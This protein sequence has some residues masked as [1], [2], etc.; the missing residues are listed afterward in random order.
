MDEIH[1][2]QSPGMPWNMDVS[3]MALVYIG[4]GLFYKDKIKKL[5][6]SE[7]KKFD[8]TARIVV[9]SLAFFCWFIYRDGNRLYY[10]DMKPVYYKELIS[11]IVIPCAFGIVLVRLVHWMEKTK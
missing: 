1:L 2:L 3:L 9:V 7:Q 11:A 8:L 4:V 6:E 5:M 10:F